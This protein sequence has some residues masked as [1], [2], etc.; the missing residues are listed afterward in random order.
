MQTTQPSGSDSA[1]AARASISSGKRE[2]L[3]ALAL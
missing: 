1:I 3:A 2:E